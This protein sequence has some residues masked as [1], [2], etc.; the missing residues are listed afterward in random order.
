MFN[1]WGGARHV[2]AGVDVELFGGESDALSVVACGSG[3]DT[4]LGLFW[5]EGGHEV[6]GAA[7]FVGFY[8]G[9]VFAFDPYFWA[10]LIAWECESFEWGGL[11][12]A[13]DALA[14]E[15]DFLS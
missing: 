7:P 13:V 2:D 1:A 15:E 14:C 11:P 4:A 10:W 12:E 5:G 8:G 3:D 9:E 6:A